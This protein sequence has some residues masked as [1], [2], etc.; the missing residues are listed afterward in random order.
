MQIGK[1]QNGV[2]ITGINLEH[3]NHIELT[4]KSGKLLVGTLLD[5]IIFSVKCSVLR[6]RNI[7][8]VPSKSG[9]REKSGKCRE[10]HKV[11][12]FG[13]NTSW[14]RLASGIIEMLSGILCLLS[15]AR[16]WMNK[17]LRFCIILSQIVRMKWKRFR[18]Y[19]LHVHVLKGQKKQ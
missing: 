17:T 3:S 14:K 4:S 13:K 5:F 7:N 10:F 12:K 9:I 1:A 15:V 16:K 6:D 8:R 2:V 11:S 19:F 18:N